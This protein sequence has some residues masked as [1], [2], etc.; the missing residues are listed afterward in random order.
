VKRSRVA[1]V[2]HFW[3]AV[4]AAMVGAEPMSAELA[5]PRVDGLRTEVLVCRGGLSMASHSTPLSGDADLPLRFR[6]SPVPAGHEG[7]LL[8]PGAC[9]WAERPGGTGESR[10]VVVPLNGPLAREAYPIGGQARACAAD[11]TCV[12]QLCASDTA[13]ELRAADGV[14][15]LTF[16]AGSSWHD[17]P[18]HGSIRAFRGRR[19]DT[20]GK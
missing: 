16:V 12:M 10:V 7:A 18:G 11:F 8:P 4:A 3:L 15:R 20:R 14:I 19:A 17:S 13:R 5:C 2:Q 6:A 1:R 9:A